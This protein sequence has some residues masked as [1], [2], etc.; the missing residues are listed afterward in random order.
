MLQF[1]F[2]AVICSVL[3]GLYF[4]FTPFFNER[5]PEKMQI[6]LLDGA[7]VLCAV[8]GILKL[9]LIVQPDIVIIGDLLPAISCLLAAFCLFLEI[10]EVQG[11][12]TLS[13]PGILDSIFAGTYRKYIGFL[14]VII[15]IL[16]FFIPAVRMF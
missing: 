16:H 8:T 14:L 12:K 6:P 9:F 3:T 5:I 7:F 1:Y 13:L 15:G 4:A 10:Y 2:L 11:G